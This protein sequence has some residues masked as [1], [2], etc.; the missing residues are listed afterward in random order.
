[1]DQREDAQDGA[2]VGSPTSATAIRGIALVVYQAGYDTTTEEGRE[3]LSADLRW[4]RELRARQATRATRRSA[5]SATF[6][7][8]IITA[9]VTAVLSWLT[10]WLSRGGGSPPH[11]GG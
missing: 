8:A 11:G 6:W 1:M 7:T 10:A 2:Y 9:V 5:W 3:H 4:L